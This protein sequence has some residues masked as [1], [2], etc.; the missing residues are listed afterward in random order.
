MGLRSLLL[1]IPPLRRW[2][3]RRWITDPVERAVHN[4]VVR[5]RLEAPAPSGAPAE[6]ADTEH[7]PGMGN[8][9]SGRGSPL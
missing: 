4:E 2:A 5:G 9:S 8:Q 7:S 1:R 6:P 3:E